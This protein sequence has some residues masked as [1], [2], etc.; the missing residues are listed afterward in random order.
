MPNIGSAWAA[1]S[2]LAAQGALDEA[3]KKYVLGC[4]IGGGALPDAA[5]PAVT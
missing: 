2:Q 3:I 5:T 4:V 1:V